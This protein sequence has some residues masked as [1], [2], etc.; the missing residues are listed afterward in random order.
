MKKISINELDA[1]VKENKKDFPCV[2]DLNTWLK[3]TVM[4]PSQGSNYKAA[5]QASR[6]VCGIQ[7]YAIRPEAA[8]ADLSI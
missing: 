6:I 5:Y 2:M 7:R 1:R 8:R 3:Q 4:G